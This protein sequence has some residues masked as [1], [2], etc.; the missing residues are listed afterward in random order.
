MAM[1]DFAA[2]EL[3][4]EPIVA[5]KSNDKIFYM[6]L[7]AK[8]LFGEKY[9][10]EDATLIFSRRLLMGSGEVTTGSFM[11]KKRSYI[12]TLVKINGFRT[13]ITR[14]S[15]P[16]AQLRSEL[17]ALHFEPVLSVMKS[18]S[19]NIQSRVKSIKLKKYKL[20]DSMLRSDVGIFDHACSAMTRLINHIDYLT[21][22]DDRES[23]IELF[24][25]YECLGEL[26]T[27]AATLSEHKNLSINFRA[28]SD[29]ATFY[30]N[31]RIVS[32]L[33]LNILSNSIKH[34]PK[35]SIISMKAEEPESGLFEITVTDSGDGI[36]AE[37]QPH[38]FKPFEARDSSE[39]FDGAGLG[40]AVVKKAAEYHNGCVFVSSDNFGTSVTVTISS[41]EQK[42]LT[43]REPRPASYDLKRL[44]LVEL[45]DAVDIQ[46][47]IEK[48]A[49][50]K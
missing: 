11:F 40:L 15:K 24:D 48:S 17:E 42:E 14:P 18:A 30:G 41:F 6:N 44:A 12:A 28:D 34:S 8:N 19:A 31:K 23:E 16:G 46:D 47:F 39:Y 3:F 2:F 22:D 43:V 7:A 36:T 33:V 5:V 45:A 29:S 4:V 49:P 25:L 10:K 21:H 13:I 1:Q 50:E 38:L 26:A 37:K 27:M 20:T 35:G 9:L 32:V